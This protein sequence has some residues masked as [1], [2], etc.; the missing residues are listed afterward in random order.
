MPI[1]RPRVPLALLPL[2]LLAC[3]G[4]DP[5]ASEADSG[6]AADAAPAADAAVDR[7]LRD[8]ISAVSPMR[9]DATAMQQSDWFSRRKETLERLRRGS[10]ELGKAALAGYQDRPD[11][12]RDVRAALLDV[13]AHCAPDETRPVLIELVSTYGDDLGLRKK[14][15]RYLAQTSPE[16]AIDLLQP[17]VSS[18]EQRSTYPPIEELLESWT[19]AMDLI[20]RDPAPVL[21]SIATDIRQDQATRHFAIR[22]LGR[23]KSDV[24]RQALE[25]LLVESLGN[26]MMRRFAAQ[27]LRSTVDKQQL[28][29]LISRV[30]DN[31]S[32]INMQKFLASMLEENCR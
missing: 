26:N 21:A 32:D 3:G 4:P 22:Q 12:L 16:Q 9:P 10:P 17:I 14:A 2:F 28:C 5:A 20:E 29:E 23:H 31:E 24:G 13:A 8:L 30:F 1:R 27:S 15:A 11:S 6:T 7:D 25:L 19:I 18:T